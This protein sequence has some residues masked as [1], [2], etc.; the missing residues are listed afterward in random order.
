MTRPVERRAATKRGAARLVSPPPKGEAVIAWDYPPD[1]TRGALPGIVVRAYGKFFGVQLRDEP[2]LLLSTVRGTLRRERRRTDLVAVG[3]RVWVTDAGEGEGQI[4]AIEPRTRVLARLARGTEDTEQ[5]ILANPDQA[6]FLFS[7]RHPVPHRRLLD[8]FLVLAESR[9]LPA[10]IAVNKIDLDHGESGEALRS[11][12]TMFG[13][14]ERFYPV[15]YIS[16]TTGAGVG[17]LAERLHGKV[18]VVAGPS[19]AGKSSLLNRLDPD[20]TRLTGEISTATGKGKHTTTA[21]EIFRLPGETYVADT[22]GIRAL[23]LHGV[24]LSELAECFPELR[25]YTGQCF[26]PDCSHMHEPGCAIRAAVDEAAISRERYE[27]YAS[28]RRGDVSE[29]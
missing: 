23:A 26:Y 2:R 24:E 21:A 13:D 28:L 15:F 9:Q 12:R 3:D 27:S 17:E 8:R 6:L 20:L 29:D 18:T 16:V 4:E 11:A 19:G 22:P 10:L 7:I 14:Y 25:P 5:I 1:S